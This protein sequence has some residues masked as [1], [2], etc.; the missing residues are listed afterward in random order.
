LLFYAT[1]LV[2]P[3]MWH[4]A[5]RL[6]TQAGR[7]CATL[8]W[9][10]L[11]LIIGL[12][13]EVGGDW[14][15]YLLLYKRGLAYPLGIALALN[16]PAYV[17]AGRALAALGFGVAALNLL[18]AI[19]FSTGVVLLCASRP[20][21]GLGLLIA[22]PVL[23]VVVGMAFTRQSAAAGLLMMAVV[24]G[25]HGRKRVAAALIVF[26]LFWH[27]SA[28]IFLPIIPLFWMQRPL[29]IAAGVVTGTVLFA[30]LAVTTA[31]VPAAA[32]YVRNS[33]VPGG[34]MLRMLPTAGTLLLLLVFW[35][36]FQVTPIER[37]LLVCWTA[38]AT[39]L[40]PMA[41]LVPAMADR[42][43]FYAIV[44]QIAV[45]TRIPDVLPWLARRASAQALIASPY[46]VLYLGWLSLS[47]YRVCWM[48]YRTYLASPSDMLFER[49]LA[50]LRRSG[51]C[52]AVQRPVRQVR[53]PPAGQRP[54]P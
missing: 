6:G 3:L 36:R 14:E 22:L 25:G 30:L 20:R 18:C 42:I 35:R 2:L 53:L 41:F 27:W 47:S 40:V 15:T 26:A 45:L 52:E 13:R 11:V 34:A 29:P 38:I 7:L 39:M 5:D 49:S 51:A 19:I 1:L 44:G 9:L 23:V 46:I 48:P 31:Y 50:Q 24:V 17:L 8:V 4:V 32:Q 12:R 37:N 28:V 16:D 54:P 33:G 43:G 10:C 21:P